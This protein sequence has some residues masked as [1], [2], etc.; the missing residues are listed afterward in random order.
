MAIITSTIV[1][2]LVGGLT[3]ALPMVVRFFERREE[4]RFQRD[5]SKLKMEQ[6]RYEA[7]HEI[8]VVNATADAFEG[9][10]LR[11]H[12]SSLDTRGFFGALRVSVRPI[13]TYAFFIAFLAI[14]AIAVYTFI[15]SGGSGDWLG[16]ALAWSE[17]YPIIWDENTQAIF[18]AIMG[19]WFG[20]RTIERL[21]GHRN[22]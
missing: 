5:L 14:K 7:E 21:G 9:E 6:A 13:I 17:I 18:G 15:K 12:D 20:S 16:N 8:R 10:S 3:S 1:G 22:G 19:F 11:R 2:T 4:L